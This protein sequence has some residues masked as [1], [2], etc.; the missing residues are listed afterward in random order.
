M[1]PL[2][3]FAILASGSIYFIF[4]SIHVF[5]HNH[6]LS[7]YANDWIQFAVDASFFVGLVA[8]FLCPKKGP[9]LTLMIGAV[10]HLLA[11][12][13]AYIPFW[14]DKMGK[15]PTAFLMSVIA[16]IGGQG[17]AFVFLSTLATL[18]LQYQKFCISLVNGLV[19]SYFLASDNIYMAFKAYFF[20]NTSTEGFLT[21]LILTNLAIF[22]LCA[23]AYPDEQTYQTKLEE[24]GYDE[25]KDKSA[26]FWKL[27]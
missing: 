18:M 20:T 22:I 17:A 27:L 4:D 21:F 8:G 10:C 7:K 16:V 2:G 3:L 5:T 1:L 15:G 19:F 26:L 13:L 6:G 9:K 23:L 24:D 14:A 25:E 12:F 11:M